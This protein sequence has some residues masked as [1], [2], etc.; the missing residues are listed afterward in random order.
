MQWRNWTTSTIKS[1]GSMVQVWIEPRRVRNVLGLAT[2]GSDRQAYIVLEKLRLEL[3][4]CCPA[5]SCSSQLKDMELLQP[6]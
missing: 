5:P 4:K 1:R 2:G 6:V 3:F